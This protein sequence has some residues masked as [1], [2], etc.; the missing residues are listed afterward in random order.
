MVQITAERII[1]TA[2]R[3]TRVIGPLVGAVLSLARA[4]AEVRLVRFTLVVNTTRRT[5]C[6]QHEHI[7]ILI[8]EI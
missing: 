1:T 2:F 4:A 5:T 6:R 3:F 7:M 8:E